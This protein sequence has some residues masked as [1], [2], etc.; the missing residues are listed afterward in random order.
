MTHMRCV[1]VGPGREDFV[2][3]TCVSDV[4][5]DMKRYLKKNKTDGFRRKKAKDEKS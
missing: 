4:R 3:H 1:S 2:W 5:K